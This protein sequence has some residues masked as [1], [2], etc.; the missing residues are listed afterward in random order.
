MI[1]MIALM[2]G[3]YMVIKLLF[4]A[5]AATPGLALAPAVLVVAAMN[6]SIAPARGHVRP[7]R[8]PAPAKTLRNAL[9][10]LCVFAAATANGQTQELQL[11]YLGAAGWEMKS[12]NLVV[13]VDPYISRIDYGGEPASNGRRHFSASDYPV[14]D[15]DLI[16]K[17]ITRADFILVHHSHPDHI[18]DVPYIAKKT[19][20]K[21]ICTETATHILT[22]FGVHAQQIYTV[23]GGEDYQFDGISIRVIPSLH[24]ALSEKLYFDATRY[25]ED[26]NVPLTI[27]QYIEGGSLMF[28]CRLNGHEVLTMGSM[29]FVERE[30]EG[31]RPDVLLAG[32]GASRTEIYDYTKRLLTATGFPRFVLPTHWDNFYVPY[33]DEAAQVQARKEKAD[34]FMKEALVAS[35]RSE[36]IIPVHLKPIVIPNGSVKP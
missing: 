29:N 26:P 11:R 33:E 14:S 6:A 9:L 19:G 28:L 36:V 12:G 7:N 27:S 2:G 22:A 1:P 8:V 16:D 17:I 35:P 31:L 24:S 15:T 20:A 18:L 10:A 25:T 32:A 3:S 13:L 23:K 21:V 5:D 30:V 34:P 4:A